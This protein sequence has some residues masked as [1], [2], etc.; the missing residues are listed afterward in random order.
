[1]AVGSKNLE[2]PVL[3]PW[4]RWLLWFAGCY[5]LVVGVNLVFFYHELFKTLGLAKPSPVMFVQL[6]GL[7]VALFGAGYLMVARRP[8]ENRNQLRLGLWSKALGTGLSFYH[9]AL[10]NLPA[11]YLPIVIFSDLVYLPPFVVI[12]HRLDRLARAAQ[13]S[14]RA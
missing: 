8:L 1:M 9:V 11:L 6:V 5:N 10:G 13:G 14:H 12:L 2:L 3:L 4:M 7:L